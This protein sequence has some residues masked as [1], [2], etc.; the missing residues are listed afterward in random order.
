M[1]YRVYY[2]GRN[3]G[4]DDHSVKSREVLEYRRDEVW[5]IHGYVS[6]AGIWYPFHS[7]EEV[8]VIEE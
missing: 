5:P 4:A 2:R 8:R 6:N 3:P 7:I 1:K